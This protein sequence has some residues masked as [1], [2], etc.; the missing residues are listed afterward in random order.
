MFE[1]MSIFVRTKKNFCTNIFLGVICSFAMSSCLWQS[2]DAGERKSFGYNQ[3]YSPEQP[4]AFSHELHVGTHKIQCQY[5]HSQ[6]ERSKS[7]N[8]PS[9]STC[10]NCHQQVSG[11]GQNTHVAR[12]CSI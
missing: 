3:G 4:I 6:V 12:S 1:S 7:S 8:I 11:M 10:M 9:L 5:C 2:P